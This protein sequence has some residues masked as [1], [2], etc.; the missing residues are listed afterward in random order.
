MEITLIFIVVIVCATLVILKDK[1]P[2][3]EVYIYVD[4]D[5]NSTWFSRKVKELEE[6]KNKVQGWEQITYTPPIVTTKP[7]IVKPTKTTMVVK[8]KPMSKKDELVMELE[9]LKSIKKPTVKQ[10]ESIG[11]LEAVIPNMI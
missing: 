2:E 6:N 11:I 4:E 10:K 5:D 8:N 7:T 3:K 1:S 9:Q